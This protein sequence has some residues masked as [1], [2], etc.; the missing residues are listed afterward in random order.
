MGLVEDDSILHPEIDE[1]HL[2]YITRLNEGHE[3]YTR[4]FDALLIKRN[5]HRSFFR[6]LKAFREQ[7]Q[8]ISLLDRADQDKKNYKEVTKV[9]LDS[10]FAHPWCRR[11]PLKK[12]FWRAEWGNIEGKQRDLEI[13]REEERL[14]RLLVPIW[15]VMR[16]KMFPA[17]DVLK[18]WCTEERVRIKRNAE[19]KL[20]MA[21]LQQHDEQIKRDVQVKTSDVGNKAGSDCGLDEEQRRAAHAATSVLRLAAAGLIMSQT[22]KRKLRWLTKKPN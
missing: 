3:V 9:Y 4:F 11:T 21:A 14:H 8:P 1:D 19:N 15:I 20:T 22:P 18:E 16:S 13:V 6:D 12:A 17:E 10:R 7:P 5:L 2:L